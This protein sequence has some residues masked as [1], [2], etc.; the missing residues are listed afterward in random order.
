MRGE[1]QALTVRRPHRWVQSDPLG[2]RNHPLVRSIRGPREYLG[3]VRIIVIRVLEIVV[4]DQPAKVVVRD[5]S[6]SFPVWR[7]HRIVLEMYVVG[8]PLPAAA[9]N[10]H[11]GDLIAEVEFPA[12]DIVIEVRVLAGR[13][14]DPG[15]V[16]RDIRVVAI[17]TVAPIAAVTWVTDCDLHY[18]AAFVVHRPG[19]VRR[20]S[21][22]EYHSKAAL[23]PRAGFGP[24]EEVTVTPPRYGLEVRAARV[25][26][27]PKRI[28]CNRFP[29]MMGWELRQVRSSAT[30]WA[31]ATGSAWAT[32]QR[33]VTR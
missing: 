11:A 8:Q 33:P 26:C 9:V 24:M 21:E 2:I 28:R 25:G 32:A 12:D 17:L 27:L 31:W 6:Y 16:G 20:V 14:H 30:E 18:H 5:E 7:P 23:G 22:V 10:V 15:T 19:C 3:V 1:C 29:T 4:V 13:V